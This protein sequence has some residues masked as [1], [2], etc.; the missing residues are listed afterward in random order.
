MMRKNLTV[1]GRPP[2][3]GE[4]PTE[5]P[6]EDGSA[7]QFYP[8]GVVVTEE[9]GACHDAID[10]TPAI[11]PAERDD[12]YLTV[13]RALAESKPYL[14]RPYRNVIYDLVWAED[15]GVANISITG[16]FPDPSGEGEKSATFRIRRSVA[17]CWY[18][19][20]AIELKFT[21]RELNR[22]RA[23]EK[24][25]EYKAALAMF[26]QVNA[27]LILAEA[28]VGTSCCPY[29]LIRRFEVQLENSSDESHEVGYAVE[30]EEVSADPRCVKSDKEARTEIV[31]AS[32]TISP[33]PIEEENWIGLGLSG[34]CQD[35]SLEE[36]HVS[37]IEVD[38]YNKAEIEQELEELEELTS[39]PP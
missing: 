39:P 30:W 31:S 27:T 3:V 33:E 21:N 34:K 37:V 18:L 8:G 16:I 6:V 32:S 11:D 12:A 13:A 14:D 20:D 29:S 35:V 4:R 28:F 25:E 5:Q 17:G 38:G 22:R 9:R 10:F 26:D 23:L 24:I 7:G 1:K 36:V 19:G 2:S 15:D